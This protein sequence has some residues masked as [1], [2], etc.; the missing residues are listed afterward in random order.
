M[1]CALVQDYHVVD[2]RD[3]SPEEIISLSKEYQNVIDVS[4]LSIYPTSGCKWTGSSFVDASGGALVKSSKITR[5]GIRQRFSLQEM[6]QIYSKKA[7]DVMLQILVDNL[8]VATYIDLGRADTIQS[9][10]YLVAANILTSQR[11]NEILNNPVLPH[12]Q[13]RGDF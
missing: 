8:N 10:Q 13:Y 9:I 4:D 12:E 1:I 6:N 2:V 5:L 11:A 3:L 7:S